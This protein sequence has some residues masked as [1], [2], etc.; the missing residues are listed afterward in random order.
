MVWV[1]APG[2]YAILNSN[3]TADGAWLAGWHRCLPDILCL[4]GKSRFCGTRRQRLTSAAGAA[5]ISGR[6]LAC[7]A[8]GRRIVPGSPL[9]FGRR[10]WR[11]GASYKLGLPRTCR[12]DQKMKNPS[13]ADAPEGFADLSIFFP[14]LFSGRNTSARMRI[15]PIGDAPIRPH[16]ERP[17]LAAFGHT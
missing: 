17:R 16:D 8:G 1:S 15:A 11:A 5:T 4:N 7:Q 14:D 3:H 10:L 12:V 9:H 2:D 13:R 6:A